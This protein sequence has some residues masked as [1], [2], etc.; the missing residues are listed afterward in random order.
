MREGPDNEA[1]AVVEAT[2]FRAR[3][4]GPCMILH[5]PAVSQ[6]KVPPA[7]LAVAFSDRR[8]AVA[9]MPM[10]IGTRPC[11]LQNPPGVVHSVR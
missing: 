5:V 6:H 9:A 2:V 3:A 10:M 4:R 7:S 1:A 8:A 11:C